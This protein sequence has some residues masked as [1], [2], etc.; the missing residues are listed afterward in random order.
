MNRLFLAIPVRLY[1]YEQ[2]RNDFSPLLQ[3]R[4]RDEATLH[5]TLAFLGS[6]F[7]EEEVIETVQTLERSFELSELIRFD[8][9]SA[10][11][12]FVALTENPSLQ[13]FYDRLVPAL[14]LE[15][16]LLRPHVTL[17]RVKGFSDA[18]AFARKIS[19][20]PEH[21]IGVMEPSLI[22]YRSLL[23]PQGAV[24]E[25]RKEWPL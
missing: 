21:P 4:W 12:V 23:L 2:I 10:S 19:A 15:A 17:M 18:E 16:Q 5:V 13:R 8:Y 25:K 1:G 6:R 14:N 9:F 22:L 3:G 24:Y 7:S 11:R 20:P